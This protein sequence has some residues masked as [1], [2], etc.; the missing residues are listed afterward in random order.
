MQYLIPIIL[1]V[2]VASILNGAIV[3]PIPQAMTIQ[4][5]GGYLQSLASGSVT[6]EIRLVSDNSLVAIV[7]FDRSGSVDIRV[8]NA[9]IPS[10]DDLRYDVTQAGVGASGCF[11]ALWASTA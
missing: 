4:Y 10:D 11:V 1:P 3:L 6:V 7:Q 8:A 2:P 5:A 9:A